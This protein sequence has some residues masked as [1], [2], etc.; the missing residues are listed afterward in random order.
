MTAASHRVFSAPYL[1]FAGFLMGCADI[2]PGVSGST[3]A[4]LMGIYP[5]F[6]FSIASLGSPKV[7]SAIWNLR[8]REAFAALELRFLGWLALGLVT[9]AAVLGKLIAIGLN[10]P[11]GRQYL[12]CLFTGLVAASAL[13]CGRRV[14]KWTSTHFFLA[15]LGGVLAFGVSVLRSHE[16]IA[17]VR[18]DVPVQAAPGWELAVNYDGSQQMLR[19]VP[20]EALGVMMAQGYVSD[21]TTVFSH[22]MQRMVSAGEVAQP[23]PKGLDVPLLL[24]GMAAISAMLLPGVSGSYVLLVL[25]KYPVVLGAW[26]DWIDSLKAG[27]FDQGA[28]LTVGSFLMGVALGAVTFSLLVA[29]LYR[30]YRSRTTAALTGMVVGALPAVWPFWQTEFHLLPMRLKKGLQ[31][32]QIEPRFPDIMDLHVWAAMFLGLAGFVLVTR[33][34][35]MVAED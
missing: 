12:C 22:Q 25:G 33:L 19:D 1:L 15:V 4:L 11:L 6:I 32:V 30:R 26:V 13:V 28:F 2:V 8:F 10:D 9:A 27:G 14:L 7:R 20:L 18:F 3:V 16:E 35:G 24:C 31:L 5:A 29:Y 34:S 23:I 17:P 21:E